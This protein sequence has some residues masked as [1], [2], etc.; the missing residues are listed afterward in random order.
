MCAYTNMFSRLFT[1]LY[2][3]QNS[4]FL[5]TYYNKKTDFSDMLYK[6]FKLVFQSKYIL[7]NQKR[8][9]N[10]CFNFLFILFPTQ[11]FEVIH[12]NKHTCTIQNIYLVSTYI[13]HNS[14]HIYCFSFQVTNNRCFNCFC[15]LHIWAAEFTD[16]IIKPTI[17][18][19]IFSA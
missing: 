19:I 9:K 1:I 2:L 16:M 18:N 15:I 5:T 17:S 10:L 3:V 7:A 14:L 6:S 8:M 11:T 13:I 4:V 12:T